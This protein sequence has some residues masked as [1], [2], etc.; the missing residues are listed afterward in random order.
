MERQHKQKY[1]G[2]FLAGVTKRVHSPT[3]NSYRSWIS[4]TRD[5]CWKLNKLWSPLFLESG[6][7]INFSRPHIWETQDSMKMWKGDHEIKRKRKGGEEALCKNSWRKK[8]PSS[9]VLA[10]SISLLRV[11]AGAG[12]LWPAG[13]WHKWWITGCSW[14]WPLTSRWE[15]CP[16]QGS[17]SGLSMQCRCTWHEEMDKIYLTRGVRYAVFPR[18]DSAALFNPGLDTVLSFSRFIKHIR[19]DVSA[20]PYCFQTEKMGHRWNKLLRTPRKYLSRPAMEDRSALVPTC[21]FATRLSI[22]ACHM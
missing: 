11:H 17:F 15:P 2:N 8:N 20:I 19:K 10:A 9:A 14:C 1:M 5:F 4:K 22:L 21:G 16:S 18:T 12:G 6:R 7:N 3:L 13:W